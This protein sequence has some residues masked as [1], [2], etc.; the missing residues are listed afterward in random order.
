MILSLYYFFNLKQ[1]VRKPTLRIKFEK[2]VKL[3]FSWLKKRNVFLQG[4]FVKEFKI[5]YSK[6]FARVLFL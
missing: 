5:K 1:K 6:L 2:E 3:Q 4:S